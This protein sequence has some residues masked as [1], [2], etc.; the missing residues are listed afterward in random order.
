MILESIGAKVVAGALASTAVVGGG[1]A[2]STQQCPTG[3]ES[4]LWGC[5]VVTD[6][7][8]GN[9]KTKSYL[10]PGQ[11]RPQ[12]GTG[13]LIIRDE[14]GRDTGSGIGE[15]QV[16]DILECGP[17]GS[18]LVLVNQDTSVHGGG[19]GTLYTGYVK[20]KYVE[21]AKQKLDCKF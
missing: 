11:G 19:W 16:F 2:V 8:Y 9:T 12:R 3:Q 17:K 15:G 14:D 13:G 5:A 18:G 4:T 6:D 20:W 21:A 1:Y 7:P 10:N